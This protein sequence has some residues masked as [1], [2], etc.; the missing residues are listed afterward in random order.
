MLNRYR[1][2]TVLGYGADSLRYAET[3]DSAILKADQQE[4]A[5]PGRVVEIEDREEEKNEGR[6]P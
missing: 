1:I 6:V 4:Q 3:R 5:Y 2:R